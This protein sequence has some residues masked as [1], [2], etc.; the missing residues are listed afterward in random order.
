MYPKILFVVIVGRKWLKMRNG[1]TK[2]MTSIMQ[3]LA[4]I[5][6]ESKSTWLKGEDY[7][8]PGCGEKFRYI[9]NLTKHLKHCWDYKLS[10]GKQK[11]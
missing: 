4:K 7:V 5:R 6:A 1:G 10:D 9:H 2:N 3:R 8:C 11:D